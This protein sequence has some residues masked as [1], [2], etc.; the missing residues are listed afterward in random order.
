MLRD[1]FGAQKPEGV[2]NTFDL[3]LSRMN[4]FFLLFPIS[5]A[6]V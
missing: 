1:L 6:R 4:I 3:I 5:R 2:R